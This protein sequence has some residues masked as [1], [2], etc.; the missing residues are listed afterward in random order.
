MKKL[1]LIL[2]VW[3]ASLGQALAAVDVNTADQSAL[4]TV[5]GIGP[6]KAKALVDERSAHGPFKDR[7]DLSARVKGF[8]TKTVDRL[9][10]EGLTI[11][12][13]KAAPAPSKSNPKAGGAVRK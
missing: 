5:K 1:L 9:L 11:G 7:A 4:Q 6:A 3:A 13:A 10:A 2:L 12:A 8:G